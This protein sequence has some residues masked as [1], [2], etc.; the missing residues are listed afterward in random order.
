MLKEYKCF[1]LLC[2]IFFFFFFNCSAVLVWNGLSTP[3]VQ[4]SGHF[5]KIPSIFIFIYCVVF[6][7]GSFRP[8]TFIKGILLF[9]PW[10]KCI[11]QQIFG[12]IICSPALFSL[13]LWHIQ[14]CLNPTRKKAH[15]N[16]QKC[17]LNTPSENENGWFW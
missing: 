1:L 12:G 3:K 6:Y 10:I 14:G 7:L 5:L 8:H 9:N 17:V 4:N 15:I 11:L 16:L 2:I 13:Y